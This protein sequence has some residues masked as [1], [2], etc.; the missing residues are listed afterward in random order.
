MSL[1]NH[2]DLNHQSLAY[3]KTGSRMVIQTT[4]A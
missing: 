4:F 3:D 2:H 1:Q